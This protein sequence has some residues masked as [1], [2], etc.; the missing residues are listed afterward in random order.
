[1]TYKLSAAILEAGYS[2]A[3]PASVVAAQTKGGF[4]RNR[5]DLDDATLTVTVGWRLPEADYDALMLFYK[6]G[7]NYGAN[8]FLIDL[9]I[10]NGIPTT[11]TAYFGA[12]GPQL[13]QV[14]GLNY[15]VTATL[16]VVANIIDPV[17]DTAIV[18]VFNACSDPG[19]YLDRFN[20][21]VNVKWP[22]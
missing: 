22:P 2:V 11:S 12:Q 17:F 7:T 1:M 13:T 10:D 15:F 8:P 9:V 20:Q 16:E 21:I 19:T 18:T 5:A 3:E 14:T 6:L 4:G